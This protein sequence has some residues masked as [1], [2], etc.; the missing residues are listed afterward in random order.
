[1]KKTALYILFFVL[2][3]SSACKKLVVDENS[4]FVGVWKTECFGEGC[5][6]HT[7]IIRN[8]NTGEYYTDGQNLEPVSYKGKVR[9]NDNVLKIG[10]IHKF[11]IDQV[12]TE[13][14]DSIII[15]CPCHYGDVYNYTWYMEID[16]LRYYKQ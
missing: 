15:Y 11:E 4:D 12:P 6:Q 3:F 2:V 14:N 8:D 5:N 1:M 9:I 16:G 7:L 10:V 13:E